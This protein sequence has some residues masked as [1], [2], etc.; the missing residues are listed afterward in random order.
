MI[1]K[2]HLFIG[3][4]LLAAIVCLSSVNASDVNA[5][6]GDDNMMSIDEASSNINEITQETQMVSNN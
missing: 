6:S 2:K 4:L 3:L 5:T 1:K